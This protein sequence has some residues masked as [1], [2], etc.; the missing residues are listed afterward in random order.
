M[1][2]SSAAEISRV[3]EKSSANPSPPLASS[4]ARNIRKVEERIQS[5][6]L[7]TTSRIAS[8]LLHEQNIVCSQSSCLRR[9]DVRHNGVLL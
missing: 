3:K 6:S 1:C 8:N 5:I 9:A 2:V 4:H 7:K